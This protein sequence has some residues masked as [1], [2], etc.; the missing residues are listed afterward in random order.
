M[1]KETP[2]RLTQADYEGLA[3]FRYLIRRFLEFSE[4]AARGLGLAPQ[5]HQALLAIRGFPGNQ[6]VT[7]GDLAERLRIRHQSAVGLV[8]RLAQAG[9]LLREPDPGDHRRILLHLTA[10]ADD[11]L[12]KLSAAHLDEL[13]RLE[14]QLKRILAGR[15]RS[16]RLAA[17]GKRKGR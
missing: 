11:R 9:L 12:A 14:P 6:T 3:E 5:Q 7:I 10:A 1:S 2:P 4:N 17:R 16:R 13:V 15:R 8:D